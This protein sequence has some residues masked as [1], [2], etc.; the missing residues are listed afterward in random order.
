MLKVSKKLGALAA[1]AFAM[2]LCI[3]LAGCGSSTS[4]SSAASSGSASAGSASSAQVSASSASAASAS[5]ASASAAASA[6]S[7]SATS[8][9]AS[10]TVDEH[11]NITLLAIIDSTGPE[12]VDL[13]QQ[14]GYEWNAG[15]SAWVRTVDGAMFFS[16]NKNGQYSQADYSSAT[17][18]GGAVKAVACN[19][20]GGYKDAEAALAGN[21][22]CVVEESFFDSGSGRGVAIVYGPSMEEY[23]VI[24][25][26]YT[27]STSQLG[28]YSKQAVGSGLLDEIYKTKVGG[29]IDEAWET[30][31]GKQRSR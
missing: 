1:G 30:L 28:M 14:Q 13:L 11:L 26:P 20:V 7:A 12:L 23:L 18:K 5:A 21:A 2:A 29:S 8:A 17:S 4:S 3:A 27:E 19:I 24:A 10:D 31:T 22:H 16:V 6:K 9:A 15:D 25:E